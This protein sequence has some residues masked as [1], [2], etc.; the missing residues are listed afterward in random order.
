MR[1]VDR[2]TSWDADG[3]G[4]VSADEIPYHFQVT[5]SRGALSGLI[6][7]AADPGPRPM[8]TPRPS[9]PDAGPDWFRLMDRNQDGDV[10]RR[11]F[12]GPREQFDRLDRDRDGLID[13]R[14]AAV[15]APGG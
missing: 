7:D 15:K 11:E 9:P 2:V 4:R 12:L 3:D 5:L 8:T 6:G 10:S 13:A 14:E 1:T